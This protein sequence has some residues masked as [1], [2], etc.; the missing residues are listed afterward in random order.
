MK[1]QYFG[2]VGDYGKYALLREFASKG[3][4]VSV[5]W[6]LTD[7]V[8]AGGDGSCDGKF[9]QY[10]KDETYRKYCPEVF[11][12]LRSAV[13]DQDIRDVRIIENSDVIPHARYFNE[14]LPDIKRV[15][16]EDRERAR[17]EWHL[18][19]KSFCRIADLVFLDPDNGLREKLTKS[20]KMDRKYVLRNE[21]IDYYR[22]GMNV[23]YYCSKGRRSDEKWRE[24]KK[25]LKKDLPDADFFGL[26]F[27]RGTQRSFIFAVHPENTERYREI[28]DGFMN[29]PWQTDKIFT[30][31]SV[32]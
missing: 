21:A 3:I 5:N 19:G 15:P 1:N 11:D 8:I 24:Y 31:E 28:A 32:E 22:S 18:R 27:H 2:D 12:L 6:Y 20:P 10:L 25:T 4:S 7:N 30:F 13:I 26:T 29:T 17:Q 14:M 23:V 9:I 16:R